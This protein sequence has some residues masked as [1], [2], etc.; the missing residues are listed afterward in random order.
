[1]ELGEAEAG[2]GERSGG[3]GGSGGLTCECVLGVSGQ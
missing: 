3:G 1:M 2:I